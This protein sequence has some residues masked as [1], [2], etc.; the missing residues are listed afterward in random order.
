MPIDQEMLDAAALWAVRTQEP[1]FE[2]WAAFTEWLE[3]NRCH[4]EAYD[5]VMLAAEDGA[6]ALLPEPANDEAAEH[7]PAPFKIPL[8]RLMSGLAAGL[9]LIAALWVWQAQGPMDI[10]RTA[11][12]ETRLIALSDG[13]TITMAGGTRIAVD[14]DGARYARLDHGQA[15]FEIRHNEG[16]PFML[17][18][19][20]ARLVDAGTIF[21]VAVRSDDV[22]VGVAEGAVIFNPDRQN[23]RI[24]PGEAL[25][26]ARG[27]N[28]FAKAALP[29][30]QVGEWRSGRL[31]FRDAALVDV[32]ADISR[33]TG[34]E[35]VVAEGAASR[36]INGSVMLSALRSDPGSLGPLLGITVRRE[37]QDWVLVP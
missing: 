4:G 21:D 1:D 3:Q 15:L 10:Y 24:A 17:E 29:L 33:A 11:P 7:A 34:I 19:G 2:D 16:D 35:F 6:A 32:A 22:T 5:R 12:G 31:T 28:G 8:G 13:S 20:A 25:T 18:V 30:E 37:G 9:A 23:A 26:F 14:P 36:T 27:G